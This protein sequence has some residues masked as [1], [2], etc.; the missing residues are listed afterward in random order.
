MSIITP[1]IKKLIEDNALALATISKNGRPHNIAVAYCKVFGDKVIISNSHIKETI[2]NIKNNKQVS[3][4]VWHKN[5]EKICVG[6]EMTGR[7]ETINP[8]KWYNFVKNMSDNEGCEIK[9]A[10]VV[11]VFKIKKLLS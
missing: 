8:G 7:A 11:T 10:I 1:G 3:L 9:S 5:W 2:S 4:V 6:F